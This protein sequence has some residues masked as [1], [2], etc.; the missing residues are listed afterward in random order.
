MRVDNGFQID[1]FTNCILHAQCFFHFGRTP[2]LRRNYLLGLISPHDPS[3]PESFD[4]ARASHY[5]FDVNGFFE[6]NCS[7]D[8]HN[9]FNFTGKLIK[10]AEGDIIW[11]YGY[12]A[13][14]VY[15]FTVGPTLYG[16]TFHTPRDIPLP[17]VENK[18]PVNKPQ[19]KGSCHVRKARN[20]VVVRPPGYCGWSCWK[21]RI[22]RP[23]KRCSASVETGIG[24]GVEEAGAV[25]AGNETTT[26]N[27]S[28]RPRSNGSNGSD[29]TRSM[30][31][32][33]TEPPLENILRNCWTEPSDRPRDDLIVFQNISASDRARAVDS[34]RACPPA[35]FLKFDAAFGIVDDL[36][37]V[38]SNTSNSTVVLPEYY[39]PEAVRMALLHS[40]DPAVEDFLTNNFT[41]PMTESLHVCYVETVNNVYF[42]GSYA[43]PLVVEEKP[44]YCDSLCH[45]PRFQ[46]CC[47]R[48]PD[49][50]RGSCWPAERLGEDKCGGSA[51]RD[52]VTSKLRRC[53][54]VGRPFASGVAETAATVA[55]ELCYEDEFSLSPGGGASLSL[56]GIRLMLKNIHVAD[57]DPYRRNND[58]CVK[59]DRWEKAKICQKQLDKIDDATTNLSKDPLFVGRTPQF[60]QSLQ[61][62]LTGLLSETTPGVLPSRH[63]GL[64]GYLF[65]N[66]FLDFSRKGSQ[67]LLRNLTDPVRLVQSRINQNTQDIVNSGALC[68]TSYTSSGSST[69]HENYISGVVVAN[70]AQGFYQGVPECVPTG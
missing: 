66:P 70:C 5:R 62:L 34:Y 22:V 48:R 35:Y 47:L 14:D 2:T 21:P 26:S 67:A 44:C 24:A 19:K 59:H 55:P 28:G 7:L 39:P 4:A 1:G 49:G 60:P 54:R 12:V 32:P 8:Q 64:F 17:D 30:E 31:E 9:G 63:T 58:F 69:F 43:C 65:K 25:A 36:Q 29:G 33:N 41:I 46:D 61:Q 3:P 57:E 15:P 18:I 23:W 50:K 56:V 51:W 45:L 40:S 53:G 11:G 6:K 38:S 37:N 13:T 68:I 16:K 42:F 27:I 52:T 10:D 20:S